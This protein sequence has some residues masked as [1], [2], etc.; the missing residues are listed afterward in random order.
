MDHPIKNIL[1]EYIKEWKELKNSKNNYETDSL[2]FQKKHG[3]QI[4]T[5]ESW[6]IYSAMAESI[7]SG[8]FRNVVIIYSST[9][10]Y[11]KAYDACNK[12][13]NYGELTEGSYTS[14]ED[15][16]ILYFSWHEL[17][18][19]MQTATQDSLNFKRLKS[20]ITNADCV[21]FLDISTANV[22]VVN[23]VKGMC[24]C[25]LIGLG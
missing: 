24:E 18:Y 22:E 19:A 16:R 17:Y 23:Q 7:D 9:N 11:H 1:E 6:P 12:L 21:F 8:G 4:K 14:L 13:A 2:T 5:P 15:C 3:L 10:S 20:M 25:C